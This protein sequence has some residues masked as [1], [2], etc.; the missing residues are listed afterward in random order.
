MVV[1][2]NVWSGR[3]VRLVQGMYGSSMTLVKYA[4]GVRDGL[5]VEVGLH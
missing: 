5:K 1:G 3:D 4:I 2:R